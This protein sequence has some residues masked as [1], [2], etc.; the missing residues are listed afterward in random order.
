M[1]CSFF[2]EAVRLQ[3][4]AIRTFSSLA[5]REAKGGKGEGGGML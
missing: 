1:Y 3:D 2:K 5:E 4:E